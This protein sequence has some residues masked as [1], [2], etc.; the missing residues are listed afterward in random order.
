MLLTMGIVAEYL[1]KQGGV[2]K[3]WGTQHPALLFGNFCSLSK[4]FALYP[5]DECPNCRD[6][7]CFS[8]FW[9][10]EQ[11]QYYCLRKHNGYEQVV[12]LLDF[13]WPIYEQ[14]NL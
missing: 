11:V 5:Q 9:F 13:M 14:C 7:D 8:L 10:V 12:Q 4:E 2:P 1:T 6:S 3:F